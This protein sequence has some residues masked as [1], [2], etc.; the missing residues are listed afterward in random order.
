MAEYSL[1]ELSS[2][3][4]YRIRN[5]LNGKCY[6]GS[7]CCF[8]KRWSGHRSHLNR[9]IHHSA[10]LQRAWN[11]YGP[12]AFVFE[13]LSL[14]HGELL[15]QHEQE[16]I[17]DLLP[18]YNVCR[19]A[20]SSAGRR[21]SEKTKALL[22]VAITGMQR[23]AETRAR[24]SASRRSRKFE[25]PK[26]METRL[27]LSAAT[28]GRPRPR[29]AEHSKKIGAAKRKVSDAQVLQIK[30]MLGTGITQRSLAQMFNCSEAL[31]SCIKTGKKREK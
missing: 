9:G 14:H 26:S 8:K 30:A 22:A 6:I 20:G 3:G 24:M 1:A 29:T 31:I 7:A 12:S 5:T 23:S 28:K 15:I 19:V 4:I 2:S 16:A 11:K 18:E 10:A 13:I 27:K 21:T 17:D 25:P